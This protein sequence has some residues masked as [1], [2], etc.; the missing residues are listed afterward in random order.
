MIKAIANISKKIQVRLGKNDKK[1]VKN[2]FPMQ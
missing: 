1:P 2:K